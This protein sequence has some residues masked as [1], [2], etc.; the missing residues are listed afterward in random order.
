SGRETI[1]PG[2]N[3]ALF[4]FPLAGSF[5]SYQRNSWD[6]LFNCSVPLPPYL[7]G[8]ILA[9]VGHMRNKGIE[10][11][12][13]YD[14]IRTPTLRWTT[15]A[16]WSTNSNR[17]VSLSNNVFR[18]SDYFYAGYTGEPIQLSTHRID[19]G[20]PIGNFYGF[21]SVDIDSTGQWIVL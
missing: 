19:V 3:L 4:D 8:T 18:T 15:S 6:M 7:S 9:N 10:A 2:V 1:N 11:Q 17:L 12:L 21:Q 14:A 16:N 5:N 20:G 13:T